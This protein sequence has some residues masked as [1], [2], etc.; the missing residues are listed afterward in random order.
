MHGSNRGTENQ[1]QKGPSAGS[2]ERLKCR[3]SIGRP[4]R[5]EGVQGAPSVPLTTVGEGT[6]FPTDQRGQEGICRI[7]Q[8]SK[9]SCWDLGYSTPTPNPKKLWQHQMPNKLGKCWPLQI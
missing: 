3:K 5:R 8:L 9:I 4:L 6:P 7:R 2:Y 1:A